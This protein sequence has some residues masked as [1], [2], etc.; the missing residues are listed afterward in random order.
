MELQKSIK[1]LNDVSLTLT[2]HILQNDGK[3]SNVVCSPLSMQV[4]LNLVAAAA[5][6]KTLD[7][8]LTFLKAKS[9]EELNSRSSYLIDVVFA[10]GSSSGGPT[11][12]LAN[13][14]WIDQSLSFKS[15]Y[16]LVVDNVYKAA[17][18]A[19]DFMNKVRHYLWFNLCFLIIILLIS[20]IGDDVSGVNFCKLMQPNESADLL[21]SW[22]E[23]ETH[24]LIKEMFPHISFDI[25]TWLVYANAIYFKGE[26]LNPFKVLNTMDYDFYLLDGSYIQVPF[27]TNF[28]C[29]YQYIS[30]F[31][32]FKVLKLH[33]KQGNDKQRKFSMN[34]FLPNAKDGLQTLVEKLG[35]EYGFLDKYLTSHME[36][37][38]KVRI[39]KFKISFGLDASKAL[40]GLGLFSSFSPGDFA[41][42]VNESPAGE[43]LFVRNAFHK[44]FIEVNEGTEAAMYGGGSAGLLINFVADHPFLFLVR[45][46]VTGVVLFTGQVLN[47]SAT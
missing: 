38:G 1:N 9:S 33:Y 27:M 32:T 8:L 30:A 31:D 24:G 34:I 15:S 41:E 2:E 46:E 36:R 4:L 21:N 43:M 37:V 45:E 16:K 22:V 19:V 18:D 5:T 7:K 3:D 26:W 11:L 6:G 29:D 44:S 12:S 13:G 47:P 14:V 39:P 23:K 20:N 40:Q 35:T 10:D 42:M 28:S 17:S 25:F